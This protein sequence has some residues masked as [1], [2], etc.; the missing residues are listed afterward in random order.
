MAVI[1]SRS[2]L[3]SGQSVRDCGHRHVRADRSQLSLSS[4]AL[5]PSSRLRPPMTSTRRAKAGSQV[6]RP[7][8]EPERVL[9]V[10]VR[11]ASPAPGLGVNGTGYLLQSHNR[12]DDVFMYLKRKP[13]AAD[14]IVPNQAYSVTFKITVASNAPSGSF[15]VGGTP[16]RPWSSRQEQGALSR[17]ELRTTD[18]SA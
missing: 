4:V 15:G 16:A 18:S 9:R 13:A 11:P 3:A 10:A 7:A 8:C 1:G 6:C 12:S 2:R 17:L 5:A 14:G